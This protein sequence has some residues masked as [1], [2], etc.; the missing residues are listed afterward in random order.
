MRLMINDQFEIIDYAGDKPIFKGEFPNEDQNISIHLLR[1]EVKFSI[2]MQI[3]QLELSESI[4]LKTE[5]TYPIKGIGIIKVEKQDQ[6]KKI[7]S[8]NISSEKQ[9]S[10]YQTK[11]YPF[12]KNKKRT[13]SLLSTSE[14]FENFFDKIEKVN[15]EL[16]KRGKINEELL[17]LNKQLLLKDKLLE[18]SKNN[19]E[20][21]LNNNLQAF[22]LVD[23]FYSSF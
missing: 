13:T 12:P 7:F 21:L 15:I 11:Y 20:A 1:D 3:S 16:D 8:V 10:N 18:R 6:N 19:I 17:S 22:I 2:L 9:E 5:N 14:Q 23:T 4:K